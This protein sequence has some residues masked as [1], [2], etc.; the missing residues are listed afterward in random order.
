MAREDDF[1][2]IAAMR[3]YGG[4]F[5]KCLAD[6]LSKADDNNYDKLEKAFPEYFER[7]RGMAEDI[8][9]KEESS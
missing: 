6:L 5:I 3:I 2:M 4:D 8:K 1:G 7:F 9:K